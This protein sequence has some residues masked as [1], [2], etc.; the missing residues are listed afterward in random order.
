[1][2][3]CPVGGAILHRL[4]SLGIRTSQSVP[5]HS[6]QTGQFDLWHYTKVPLI[7][8]TMDLRLTASLGGSTKLLRPASLRAVRKMSKQVRP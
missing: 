2:A 8:S 3:S 7:S 6:H 1:M 4:D 5:Y